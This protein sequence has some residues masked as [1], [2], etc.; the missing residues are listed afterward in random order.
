[1]SEKMSNIR[2]KLADVLSRLACW[3]RGKKWYAHTGYG[4]HGNRASELSQRIWELCVLQGH[5][6]K[7]FLDE[8]EPRLQELARLAG[9]N[10]GHRETI[11]ENMR[12]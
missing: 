9:E 2:W 5:E 8:V 10:W 12:L 1:M 3:L 4:L 11:P 7:E 6:D